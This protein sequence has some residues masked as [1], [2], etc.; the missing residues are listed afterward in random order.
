M[1]KHEK[2]NAAAIM[3]PEH[4]EYGN[5]SLLVYM[6]I[7]WSP[8]VK[9]CSKEC[10]ILQAAFSSNS[11]PICLPLL[12]PVSHSPIG[13]RELQDDAFEQRWHSERGLEEECALHKSSDSAACSGQQHDVKERWTDSRYAPY[14][15]VA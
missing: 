4:C 11:R 5:G 15:R 6:M 10:Q 1:L 14:E 12:R 3:I 9:Q 2:G 7:L 13:D 8:A